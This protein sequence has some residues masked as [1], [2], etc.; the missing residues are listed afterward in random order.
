MRRPGSGTLEL[1]RSSSTIPASGEVVRAVDGVSLTIEPGELVALYGPSGSGQDDAAAAC[2][3]RARPRRRQRQLRR[4][5]PRRPRRGGALR[6]PAP[7]TSAS[8][9]S[10]STCSPAFPRSRTPPSSCWPIGCR[11]SARGGSRSRGWTGSVSATASTTYRRGC[12]A[13]SAS[14]SRSHARSSTSRAWCS[15]T[16]RRATSTASA[17][18]RSSSCWSSSAARAKRRCCSSRTTRRRRPWPIASTRCATAS[19]S[20]TSPST[21]HAGLTSMRPLTLAY[22][23]LRRLRTHPVQE[24]LAG[25]GITI[26]VALTCAVQIANHSVDRLGRRDRARARRAAATLQ[27]S[28]RSPRGV[29]ERHRRRRCGGCRRSRRA[30]GLLEQRAV[31]TGPTRSQR[32]RAPRRRPPRDRTSSAGCCRSSRLDRRHRAAARH[33]A[34]RGRWRRSSTPCPQ[35]SSGR[36]HLSVRLSLRGRTR[37]RSR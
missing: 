20:A 22:L 5:R 35:R 15:P 8:S 34:A 26:G 24:L 32:V 27:L 7:T 6:L 1:R 30:T 2:G 23:Y 11:S 36:Q 28:A 17:A 9:I 25:L 33:R 18:P 21:A 3:R 29:P 16:S 37:A 19:C 14:A 12:P 13:E 31:L 10:P 4:A